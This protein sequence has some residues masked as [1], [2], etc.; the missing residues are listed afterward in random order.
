MHE[1]STQLDVEGQ[2]LASCCLGNASAVRVTDTA[3]SRR[4][5][6]R[7][8]PCWTCRWLHASDETGAVASDKHVINIATYCATLISRVVSHH[9]ELLLASLPPVA[10]LRT[11]VPYQ[12]AHVLERPITS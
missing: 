10:P 1:T 7:R 2:G 12:L 9:A 4:T 6:Q 8:V 11:A 5:L 3:L